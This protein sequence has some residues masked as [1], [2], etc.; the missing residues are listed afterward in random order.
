MRKLIAVT[1]LFA[2]L[3]GCASSGHKITQGQIDQIVQGQTTQDDLIAIFGP[4]M[5]EQ[6]NSDGTR[7]LTWAYAYVGFA[8][9]GTEAQGLSVVLGPDGK[10]SGFSRSGATP[11]PT[12]LGP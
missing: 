8:G 5:G 7:V 2:V 1:A 9:V 11:A 3:A 6:Y 12:R 10:V 4:P